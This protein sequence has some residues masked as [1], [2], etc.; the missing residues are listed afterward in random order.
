M[1]THQLIVKLIVRVCETRR[2]LER[3]KNIISKQRRNK[4]LQQKISGAKKKREPH[5]WKLYST[6]TLTRSRTYSSFPC[7]TFFV[8]AFCIWARAFC[9]FV[10]CSL[11]CFPFLFHWN[12]KSRTYTKFYLFRSILN[13]STH[14]QNLIQTYGFCK[15]KQRQKIDWKLKLNA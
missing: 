5:D 6:H 11:F 8:L 1:F 14:F 2:N 10:F 4:M 7:K 3:Q 12:L 15:Q 9:F 13:V